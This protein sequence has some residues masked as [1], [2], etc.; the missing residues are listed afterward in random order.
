MKQEV[1]LLKRFLKSVGIYG[2]QIAKGGL[3]GYVTEIL[4]LKYGTFVSTL[5]SIADISSARQ[6]MYLSTKLITMF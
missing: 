3:S 4:I 5:Q 1:R 2:A 6:M